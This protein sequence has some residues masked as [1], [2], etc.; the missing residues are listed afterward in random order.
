MSCFFNPDLTAAL[1]FPRVS[2]V[3]FW[4]TQL[5]PLIV[6]ATWRKSLSDALYANAVQ[7]KVA[8]SACLT[9]V[10]RACEGRLPQERR[11]SWAG[12]FPEK[13]LHDHVWGELRTNN[14]LIVLL[15][16]AV[17]ETFSKWNCEANVVLWSFT[18]L[19]NHLRS[20]FGMEIKI[21]MTNQC[22]FL[23]VLWRHNKRI[24]CLGG[25]TENRR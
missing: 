17:R 5:F 18:H 25:V 20:L 19:L 24:I 15:E 16:A 7:W 21:N 3:V 9:V 1:S 22:Y 14:I 12:V 10:E 2:L 13:C 8:C 6:T 4:E 23:R 11:S